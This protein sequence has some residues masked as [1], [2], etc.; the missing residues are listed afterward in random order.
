VELQGRTILV[1]GASS[2]IGAATAR[3]V[4][5]AG[6]HAVVVARTRPKLDALTAEIE[7]AGGRAT[8]YGLDCSDRE[9]VA[10][11]A[12][13]IE[14]EVGTP[15]VLVNNAGAGRFLFFEETPPEEFER[16]MSAPFYSTVYMTRALLPGMIARGSGLIVNVN[17]PIAFVA[18]PAAAG[19][20]SARW[21]LRGLTDALSADLHG[22]GVKVSQVVP[23][24]VDSTYF[25][26]NPGAEDGIPGMARLVR[27]L[28]PDEVADAI[29]GTIR[30]EKRLVFTPFMLRVMMLQARVFPRLTRRI[31]I[32]TSRPRPGAAPR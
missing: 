24:K 28:T 7:A 10:R 11:E 32:R 29:V 2:G 20:A 22:T 30:S 18:W 25:E 23:G 19:Y 16:M 21:A 15:D 6:A 3:A 4:A 31:A 8:A 14:D 17:T 26:H 13:R 1:T 5:R 9:A 12:A 27:T